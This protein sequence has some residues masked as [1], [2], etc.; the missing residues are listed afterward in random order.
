MKDPVFR[1]VTMRIERDEAHHV[2]FGIQ[3][4]KNGIAEL[5]EEGRQDLIAYARFL[6]EHLWSMTQPE[7]WRA[8]FD[9]C[10]LDYDECFRRTAGSFLSPRLGI[11]KEKSVADMHTQ[12]VRWFKSALARVGLNEALETKGNEDHE[13][14]D[15]SVS[16]T[17]PWIPQ[18]G[19]R[20]ISPRRFSAFRGRHCGGLMHQAHATLSGCCAAR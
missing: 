14:H 6:D 11:D 15:E 13:D 18:L 12:F 3:Y 16:E 5:G 8:A 2:A 19:I 1:D 7:E 4:L 9:E 17:L 20:Y 10:D